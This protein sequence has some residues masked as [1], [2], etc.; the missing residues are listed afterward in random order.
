MKLENNQNDNLTYFNISVSARWPQHEQAFC[1][2]FFSS[3]E[4]TRGLIKKDGYLLF[5]K[6]KNSVFRNAK[7]KTLS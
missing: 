7:K 6:E 5:N 1:S 4:H 3:L 2:Y